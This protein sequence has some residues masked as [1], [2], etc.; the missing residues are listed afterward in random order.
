MQAPGP[1]PL[2]QGFKASAPEGLPAFLP[3]LLPAFAD[4]CEKTF[5][6]LRQ[7]AALAAAVVPEGEAREEVPEGAEGWLAESWLPVHSRG[8]GFYR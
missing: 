3:G 8:I 4:V 5:V 2:C 1:V 6:K 7:L